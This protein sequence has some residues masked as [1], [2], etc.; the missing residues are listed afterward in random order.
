MQSV[1]EKQP[2][3]QSIWVY[4]LMIILSF[5][6]FLYFTNIFVGIEN[7]SNLISIACI[8]IIIPS[9]LVILSIYALIQFKKIKEI[10]KK[11]LLLLT[12]A[13]ILWFAAEQTWNFYEHVLEIDPYPSLADL[14]YITAP[15]VMFFALI[16]YLKS[17]NYKI[18]KNKIILS[19]RN[20]TYSF[21]SFITHYFSSWYRR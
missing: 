17:L 13:F 20:C 6:A 3:F 21:D 11:P 16:S 12:C 14:F 15:I 1:S 5:V 9:L 2:K 19:S 18:S 4:S 8:Y 7:F 10:S